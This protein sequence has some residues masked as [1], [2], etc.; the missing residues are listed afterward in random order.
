M[1]MFFT[2]TAADGKM[3][4]RIKVAKK[5]IYNSEMFAICSSQNIDTVIWKPDVK[6][7][8]FFDLD[9]LIQNCSLV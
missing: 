4:Y 6:R 5:L 9:A 1:C 8:Q 7:V 2:L 3:F